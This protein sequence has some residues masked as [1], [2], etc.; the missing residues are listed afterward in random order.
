MGFNACTREEMALVDKITEMADALTDQEVD[1]F[2]KHVTRG[3]VLEKCLDF[4][5]ALN[6]DYRASA[7]LIRDFHPYL[8]SMFD[9]TEILVSEMKQTKSEIVQESYFSEEETMDLFKNIVRL[10][11]TKTTQ[12]PESLCD[13]KDYYEKILWEYA[14]ELL[15]WNYDRARE[16]IR[17]AHPE[18][19]Q[20][21]KEVDIL[22]MKT[23]AEAITRIGKSM[24]KVE[25]A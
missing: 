25:E 17:L 21:F 10:V 19:E 11:R 22:V 23:M 5:D 6:N 14:V 7:Q 8:K 9:Q 18:M 2:G 24:A 13:D 15:K 1:F 20:L 12:D 4:A 3:F 16:E